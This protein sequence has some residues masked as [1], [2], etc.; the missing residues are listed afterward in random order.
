MAC[1]AVGGAAP[2]DGGPAS[3][4]G[5]QFD[6]DFLT[7]PSS[8]RTMADFGTASGAPPWPC[9]DASAVADWL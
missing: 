1:V 5:K 4:N 9:M 8:V 3:C 6:A 7:G 2:T